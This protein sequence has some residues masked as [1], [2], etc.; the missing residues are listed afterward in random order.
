M[1]RL[2]SPSPSNG[3]LRQTERS[4]T[5]RRAVFPTWYIAGASSTTTPLCETLDDGRRAQ[6]AQMEPSFAANEVSK[7]GD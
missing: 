1:R 7:C 3:T 5:V 4:Q 2:R 6:G